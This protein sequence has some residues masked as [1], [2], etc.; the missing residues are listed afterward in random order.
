[1]NEDEIKKCKNDIVYFVEEYLGIRLMVWQ[2]AYLRAFQ[3]KQELQ[4]CGKGRGKKVLYDSI[5]S[6]KKFLSDK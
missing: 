3:H 2:K 4:W 1:M 5:A 6:Y